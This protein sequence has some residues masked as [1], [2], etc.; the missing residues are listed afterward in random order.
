MASTTTCLLLGKCRM[1]SGI[2]P[3]P[4]S[5][6]RAFPKRSRSVSCVSNCSP[7]CNSISSSSCLSFSSP[8]FPCTFTSPVSAL[9]SLSAVSP[10]AELCCML[11][12]MVASSRLSAWFCCSLFLSNA[13]RISFRLR[14][15]GSMMRDT[16]S[17]FFSASS[18]SLSFSICSDVAF[19]CSLITSAWLFTCCWF[20]SLRAAICRSALSLTSANWFS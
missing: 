3:L 14:F 9:V 16:C 19:I 18:C 12:C 8:K 13:S 6:F 15:S 4:S 20:I 5:S 10:K 17:R 2:S 1:K 11:A 7:S